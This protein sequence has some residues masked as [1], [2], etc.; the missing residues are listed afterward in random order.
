MKKYLRSPV[1]GEWIILLFL[2]PLFLFP[3]GHLGLALLLIPFFWLL[4]KLEFGWF[5][6]ATPYDLAILLLLVMTALSF[7][8]TFDASLS[9]TKIT[10][11]LYGV[12]LFYAAVSYSRDRSVW[13]IVIFLLLAGV[14]IATMGF[15][16]VA[17][18]PPFVFLNQARDIF[19]PTAL[20]IPGTVDGLIHPNELAGVLNWLIPLML[21]CLI[22]LARYLWQKSKIGLFLLAV[23]TAYSILILFATQSRGGLLGL[24][25][26][27]VAVVAFYVSPRWRIVLAVGSLVA[28][29]ALGTHLHNTLDQEVVGDTFDLTG[30]F[31]IWSR[32][33]IA[34]A[35]FPL[36]GMSMNGF[37]QVVHSLYP[38]FTIPPTTD[39]GHAHNN[40]LQTA[41]DLGLPGLI[42]YLA[43]WFISAALL[44]R[45]WKELLR[46]HARRHPYFA[47]TAGLSGSLL[48]G[49]VF[50]VFDA[51]PL[52][53]R[54]AFIWWLLLGL[55]ASIHYAVNHSG[56]RLHS[57]RR[58][59]SG[60]TTSMEHELTGIPA[61]PHSITRTGDSTS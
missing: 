8:V 48:S 39:L 2:S 10:G 47:L 9:I 27:V 30:R 54:P 1:Y 16:S 40:L 6:P 7:V 32:A 49:W 28:L 42:S 15:L 31:E 50:G 23:S 5:F 26:G 41:L 43:L 58:Y 17:W 53:A 22:G 59:S 46:R 55:T 13:P 19:S 44:W 38:L 34:I 35:D 25:V 52:G 56:E 29:V 3:T 24:G 12:A 11:L 33:L 36:T 61:A 45:T 14:M 20:V 60:A 57:R 21:A 18:P 37:R 51:V 4:R